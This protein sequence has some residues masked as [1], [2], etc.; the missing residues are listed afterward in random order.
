MA[1]RIRAV[2]ICVIITH[3]IGILRADGAQTNFQVDKFDSQRNDSSIEKD[4]KEFEGFARRILRETFGLKGTARRIMSRKS[5]ICKQDPQSKRDDWVFTS[6]RRHLSNCH[7]DYEQVTS[8]IDYTPEAT[9]DEK[10]EMLAH[11]NANL[12]ACYRETLANYADEREC[13]ED[14]IKCIRQCFAYE[15]FQ[16]VTKEWVQNAIVQAKACLYPSHDSG[17]VVTGSTDKRRSHS[18]A[19]KRYKKMGSRAEER[20]TPLSRASDSILGTGMDR[21]E[22][23]KY[24]NHASDSKYSVPWIL[25]LVRVFVLIY[26]SLP[27]NL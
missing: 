4:A 3:Q 2:L 24:R 21:R 5:K 18:G 10:K 26:W 14:A 15:S 1:Y 22:K 23:N 20:T 12:A 25:D 13:Q 11:A 9:E 6:Y 8:R 17:R 16:M 19:D 27:M 7:Y